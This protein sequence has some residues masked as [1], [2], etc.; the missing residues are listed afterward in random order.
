M[1]ILLTGAT[2]SCQKESSNALK[3]RKDTVGVYADEVFLSI[4]SEEDWEIEIEYQ[5][6]Q[7][8]WITLSESAGSGTNHSIIL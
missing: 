3:L 4:V 7:N 5:G 1:F 8:G 2:L 6:A